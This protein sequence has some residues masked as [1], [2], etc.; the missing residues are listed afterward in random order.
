MASS[1]KAKEDHAVNEL[2]ELFPIEY[3][4]PPVSTT[5]SIK[6][7]LNNSKKNS[8]QCS[9]NKSQN[10]GGKTDAE[11]LQRKLDELQKTQNF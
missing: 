8:P 2:E 7:S 10:E 9:T 5:Q 1:N 6:D 4:K 3:T 11:I